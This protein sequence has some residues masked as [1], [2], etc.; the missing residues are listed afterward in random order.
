MGGKSSKKLSQCELNVY[1]EN[2]DEKISRLQAASKDLK[3]DVTKISK[4]LKDDLKSLYEESEKQRHC[5][6]ALDGEIQGIKETLTGLRELDN[7]RQQ[8]QDLETKQNLDQKMVAVKVKAVISRERKNWDNGMNE[9]RERY[10]TVKRHSDDLLS[11]DLTHERELHDLCKRISA[12]EERIF[13]GS[14]GELQ[15]NNLAERKTTLQTEN[16]CENEEEK[17]KFVEDSVQL[18]FSKIS[19]AI[20]K[21]K[22]DINS[23]ELETSNRL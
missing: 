17:V 21:L 23:R 22:G 2:V 16:C 10:E 14:G 1:F 12:L 3:N 11:M 7:I 8:V 4:T 20:K 15:S 18:K 5:I 19:R 6:I 13:F 9:L